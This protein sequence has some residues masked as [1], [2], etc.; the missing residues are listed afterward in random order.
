VTRPLTVK[1]VAEPGQR[2]QCAR[3]CSWS[4]FKLPCSQLGSA[5]SLLQAG[6]MFC[7]SGK[8]Q[9]SKICCKLSGLLCMVCRLSSVHAL[10][11]FINWQFSQCPCLGMAAPACI[12]L[13]TL[14]GVSI[15][16]RSCPSVN[17]MAA[18]TNRLCMPAAASCC[19]CKHV[20]VKGRL[21]MQLVCTIEYNRRL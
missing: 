1:Q 14:A 16:Y 5:S 8:G 3:L 15:Q 19:K 20:R 12:M 10:C 21:C 11:E 7:P 9:S 4:S 6:L 13:C 18:P 17:A 2:L